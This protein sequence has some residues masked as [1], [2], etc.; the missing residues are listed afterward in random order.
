MIY[1]IRLDLFKQIPPESIWMFAVDGKFHASEQGPA[2]FEA[3]E[4]GSVAG[5]LSGLAYSLQHAD[6]E[7]S[8]D[9]ILMTHHKCMNGVQSRNPAQPGEFRTTIVASEMHPNWLTQEGLQ[10]FYKNKI[11]D[12]K[13]GKADA[14]LIDGKI[15]LLANL[16]AEQRKTIKKFAF[17]QYLKEQDMEE[18]KSL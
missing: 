14:A 17:N 6:E 11:A 3:R 13:I 12:A 9:E 7:L 1:K 18:F 5:I 2:G 15:V 10:W 4:A 16:S 8:V